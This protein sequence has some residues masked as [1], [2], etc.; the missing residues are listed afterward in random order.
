MALDGSARS[1]VSISFALA[2]CSGSPAAGPSAPAAPAASAPA[3]SVGWRVIDVRDETRPVRPG[4]DEEPG[5]EVRTLPVQIWYPAAAGGAPITYRDYARGDEAALRGELEVLGADAG[6]ADRLLGSVRP[7]RGGAPPAPGRFP[8]AVWL[9]GAD[10]A[11]AV[12]P[13]AEE[14][15]ARGWVVAAYPSWGRHARVQ[16]V[17]NM[18]EELE[19][20]VRD[21]EL[22]AAALGREPGV[23]AR[24]PALLAFSSGAAIAL[25]YA[26]RNRPAALVSFDGWEGRFLGVGPVRGVADADPA[27]LRTP[28]LMLQSRDAPEERDLRLIEAARYSSR[29]VVPVALGHFDLL[30]VRHAARSGDDARAAREVY[31]GAVR[32]AFDFL[33]HVRGGPAPSLPEGARAWPAEPPAPD[34]TDVARAL[35]DGGDPGAAVRLLGRVAMAEDELNQIG[36]QLLRSGRT[37][38]AVAVFTHVTER[39][40]SSANAFDSLG[41]ALLAAGDRAR[42]VEAY[43]SALSR[44]PGFPS[45]LAALERL[46]EAPPAPPAG[47]AAPPE[48]RLVLRPP[49]RL[50]RVT[51]AEL[52]GDRVIEVHHG[53]AG[54]PVVVFLNGVGAPIRTW[55]GYREW[56]Q[57][58]VA[59]GV[60]AVLYDGSSVADAEAA[61][62]H[63]ES[64]GGALRLDLDRLCVFASSANGRVGVRLPLRPSGQRIDCAVYYYPIM[65]VPAA[66]ADMPVMLVRT[67][68]DQAALLASID[69]WIGAAV[70]VNA[71]VQVVNLPRHRHGFDARDD[72]DESR[73]VIRATVDFFVRHLRPRRG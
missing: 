38:A 21:L 30:P 41:E 45:A 57:L 4:W 65:D 37:R 6:A 11:R 20:Y 13:L 33:D 12:A 67:G 22:V 24:R 9:G 71:D 59:A 46:G 16:L 68:I 49:G 58:L 14:L 2:A 51:S 44:N 64:R 61:L 18:A 5:A 25:V 32:L 42:A 50:P 1:L 60:N 28:Y 54:G 69:A 31:A 52:G 66:R 34:R 53:P 62:A 19:T 43:R 70:A 17:A 27:Q 48:Y 26:A 15:A 40:S 23:D 3:G 73:R 35:F 55:Q 7:A 56:A 63:L 72:D 47:S 10:G 29:A 8:L 36:Y 39:F